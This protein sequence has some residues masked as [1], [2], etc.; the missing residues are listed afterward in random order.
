MEADGRKEAALGAC[1]RDDLCSSTSSGNVDSSGNEESEREREI[2]PG[3]VKDDS[4][5]QSDGRGIECL[6]N[7]NGK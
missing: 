6:R 1:L 5:E 3:T 2:L 7:E 4:P